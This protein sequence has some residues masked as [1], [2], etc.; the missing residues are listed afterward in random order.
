[1]VLTEKCSLKCKEC[2]N[3]MQYYSKPVDEDFEQLTNSL[4][5]FMRTVDHVSEVRLIGG[6]PMLYKKIDLIIKQ[7]LNYKN[8]DKIIFL[9]LKLLQ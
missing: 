1:M 3:L 7:I 9:N 8:F 2:S 4:D 6:E 5:T